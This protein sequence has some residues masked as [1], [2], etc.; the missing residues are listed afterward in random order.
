MKIIDIQNY[1]EK[2][3]NKNS[4]IGYLY[5]NLENKVEDIELIREDEEIMLIIKHSN[6]FVIEISGKDDDTNLEFGIL[7]FKNKEMEDFYMIFEDEDIYCGVIGKEALLRW[8]LRLG[9]L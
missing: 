9:E 6:G 2:R 3:I 4:K 5:K 7:E 1:R 8:I